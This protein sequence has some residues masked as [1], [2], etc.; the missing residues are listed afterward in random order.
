MPRNGSKPYS[1]K[2]WHYMLRI[3]E[4][5]KSR[6]LKWPAAVVVCGTCCYKAAAKS[7]DLLKDGNRRCNPRLESAF[8]RFGGIRNKR[9]LSNGRAYTIGACAEHAAANEVLNTSRNSPRITD[10][11]FSDAYRPRTKRV[12]HYC[13]ICKG[14]FDLWN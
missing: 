14:V 7:G 11:N 10:L 13:E 1:S 2:V 6:E 3:C 8:A 12:V 9:V 5:V 4:K